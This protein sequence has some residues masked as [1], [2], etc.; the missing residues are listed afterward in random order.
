MAFL[1]PCPHLCGYFYKHT[2]TD[3]WVTKNRAFEKLLP[4]TRFSVNL[5]FFHHVYR[6]EG[7]LVPMHGII[8]CVWYLF[9]WPYGFSN[10]QSKNRN[11]C[12][13]LCWITVV[14][15]VE[16]LMCHFSFSSGSWLANVSL[17]LRLQSH[18]CQIGETCDW[19]LQRDA[20]CGDQR[21]S[22]AQSD[23]SAEDI[24]C[25]MCRQAPQMDHRG[26]SWKWTCKAVLS[27]HR[28]YLGEH[29]LM[30]LATSWFG[31]H[32]AP[33]DSLHKR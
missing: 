16:P 19:Q 8:F 3:F 21:L 12:P 17:A 22:Q 10:S 15:A 25:W 31:V 18:W 26:S 14:A 23:K 5:A 1:R 29:S 7:W 27:L 9:M 24:C 4:E 13:P 33:P 32:L 2:Q 20:D 28:Q 11:L 6:G 30:H